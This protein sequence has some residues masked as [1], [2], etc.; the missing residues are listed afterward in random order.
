MVGSQLWRHVV[1]HYFSLLLGTRYE[2]SVATEQ[3]MLIIIISFVL[4]Y[5]WIGQ[6]FDT[7]LVS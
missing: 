2:F 5:L 7:Q 1:S 4:P 6:F 3:R